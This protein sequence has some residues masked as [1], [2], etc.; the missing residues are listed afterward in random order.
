METDHMKRLFLFLALLWGGSCALGACGSDPNGPV[1]VENTSSTEQHLGTPY[2][3]KIAFDYGHDIGNTSGYISDY[4]GGYLLGGISYPCN[5]MTCNAGWRD[6]TTYA[7]A[8]TNI[9]N[10]GPFGYHFLR[11][12]TLKRIGGSPIGTYSDAT[13][14]GALFLPG[15]PS[16]GEDQRYVW[17]AEAYGKTYVVEVPSGTY[18]L[19]WSMGLD[20]SYN[21]D[22]IKIDQATSDTSWGQ[23]YGGPLYTPGFRVMAD[24]YRKV[25]LKGSTKGKLQITFPYGADQNGTVPTDYLHWI[26]LRQTGA[27]CLPYGPNQGYDC[28]I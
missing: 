4:G 1:V 20:G 21:Y 27:L 5:G 7:V 11:A 28:Q 23:Y 13:P 12:N 14:W 10:G 26:E 3:L 15:V 24:S 22:Q 16:T 9:V 25:V 8:T 19:N 18:D 2:V 6:A 17:K